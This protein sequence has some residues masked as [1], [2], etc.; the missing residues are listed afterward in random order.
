MAAAL[1][2]AVL[3]GGCGSSKDEAKPAPE[4]QEFPMTVKAANGE[5]TIDA[6]PKRIVSLS[7]TATEML[8]A[9]DAGKQVAAVDQMSNFPAEAPKSD[10]SGF[11]PNVEAIAGR[12]PDLVVLAS[13]T[14]G[15]SDALTKLSIKTV[16]APSAKTLDDAYAQWAMLGSATG[17][18]VEAEK[19]VADMK[20]QIAKVVADTPKPDHQISYYHETDTTYFSASSKTFA[21]S[22]YGLFDL[23]NIADAADKGTGY[24]QLSSEAIVSASPELIFLADSKCCNQN[25]Q[26]VSARPG[27]GSIAA[28][29][30]HRVYALDDDVASRWGPRVVE[31][32]KSIA[33]AVKSAA[34]SHT[35]SGNQ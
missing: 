6:E 24:P 21:G 18:R 15:V 16:V 4:A 17:H 1:A 12:H 14:G 5:V 32:V 9:M 28:V 3:L 10:L 20:L 23:K 29:K 30:N 19:V 34:D 27:W 26:T 33:E 31:M 35:V 8:F 13:D 22:L 25:Q 7:P 11:K 2:A